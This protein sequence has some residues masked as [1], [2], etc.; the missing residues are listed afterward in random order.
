MIPEECVKENKN[1]ETKNN[2]L[3]YLP[4][5]YFPYT[6]CHPWDPK[7]AFLFL[8][9]LQSY[10]SLLKVLCKLEFKA[11]TLSSPT[12]RC[13]PHDM[14]SMLSNYFSLV[15]L[16]KKSQLKTYNGL[17]VQFVPPTIFTFKLKV[18]KADK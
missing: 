12:L 16:S 10:C 8:F 5:I 3:H 2:L 18:Q 15:N 4:P 1:K 9:S 17:E 13:L 7:T 6:L 14:R 11:T